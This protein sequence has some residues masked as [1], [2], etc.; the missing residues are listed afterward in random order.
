MTR[1]PR[2][3]GKRTVITGAASGIGLGIARRFAAEGALLGLIDIDREA[4]QKL[5]R[6]LGGRSERVEAL[7]VD[8]TDEQQV[9]TS[10]QG[11]AQRLGGL[12]VVVPNAAVQLFGGDASVTE[13]ELEAWQHTL[14]IN[15]TGIFLTCKHGIRAL[16]S[17]GGGS[18]VCTGSPT[19]LRGSASGF[20]AYSAS[21]A[22]V[23]GLVKIMAAD[24]AQRGVRINA[25]VPGFTDT[26]LVQALMQDDEARRQ[27]LIRTPMGRPGR[28]E[29][30]AAV[31]AFLASD[32]ASFVT[33]AL[34]TVDGGETAV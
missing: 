7:S 15:M 34:Y 24:Y 19:G 33:G 10:I 14:D 2:L 27:T 25:V 17:S 3:E 28:P 30:V 4:V 6:E 32:E 29:E 18:V 5:A 22:G 31:A 26:P 8:V 23:L 20:S 13:L 11:V 9:A 12:D 21:K 16:L 1:S